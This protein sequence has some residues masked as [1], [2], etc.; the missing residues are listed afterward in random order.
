ME[1]DDAI[2]NRTSVRYFEEKD[3]PAEHVRA[4]VEAAVRAPTASGLENWKFVIFGSENARE[5]LYNLIAEGMIRYYRAVNLPDEKIE[6]LKKRMYESGMYR[7]PVYVAVFIDRRVRFLPG[8]DFDELEFIWSV[9][10]AAM[11]IQNLMLRAVELG[12]GTVYIG[13]T[14]FQ[15]IEEEVRGLAG[16]DGNHYLV[17]VIPVGYPREET[18]P[19][20]RRKSIDE[21]LRF[22]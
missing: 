6:K 22:V 7:A 11:A 5:R 9:E 10:S 16:L 19:R 17:G 4:L 2:L 21:V 3:V 15:G 1:L 20:R 12:L 13:V 14:N 8:E 18:R